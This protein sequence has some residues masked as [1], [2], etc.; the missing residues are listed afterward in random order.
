MI[1]TG[2]SLVVRCWYFSCSGQID[3]IRCHGPGF[4]SGVAVWAKALNF[5][6]PT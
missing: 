4:S 3:A 6:A 2:I 1:T 5:S